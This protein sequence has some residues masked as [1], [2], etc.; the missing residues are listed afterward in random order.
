MENA[1]KTAISFK[2]EQVD[3]TKYK[4]IG[5]WGKYKK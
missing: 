1:E 3:K 2:I 5:K 4:E